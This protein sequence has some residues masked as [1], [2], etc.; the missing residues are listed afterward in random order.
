ML[1]KHSVY[2]LCH[3]YFLAPDCTFLKTFFFSLKVGKSCRE[4]DDWRFQT[5]CPCHWIAASSIM[6][7]T[8]CL[9]I[10]IFIYLFFPGYLSIL[11]SWLGSSGPGYYGAIRCSAISIT[12]ISGWKFSVFKGGRKQNLTW[13]YSL[14]QQLNQGLSRQCVYYANQVCLFS[15]RKTRT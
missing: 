15:N 1:H 14:I 10:Q 4:K 5:L 12:A 8:V 2:I 9:F 7:S 13:F 6:W 11:V 3:C